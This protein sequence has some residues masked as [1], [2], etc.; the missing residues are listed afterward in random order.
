MSAG[1][2][3]YASPTGSQTPWGD[4]APPAVPVARPGWMTAICI[5]ALI[6]GGLGIVMSLFGMGS[7]LMQEQM[8]RWAKGFGGIGQPK[9]VQDLNDQM[10]T[11]MQEVQNRWWY[12]L[13]A[14]YT[15]N[16]LLS[17]CMIYAA[18]RALA[19]RES[20]RRLLVVTFFAA[21]LFDLLS[22]IPTFIIQWESIEITK[23]FMPRIMEAS[24]PQ[25]QQMPPA[26]K[27]AMTTAMG[28]G[29]IVVVA[30]MG[31]FVLAKII[32]YVVSGLY[33]NKAPIRSLCQARSQPLG[34]PPPGQI[35]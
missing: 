7:L 33:L 35:R 21:T 26:A 11:A 18:A 15:L 13:I 24:A 6:V 10:Q 22:L 31:L 29:M 4:A 19:L 32:F 28:A 2:N 23:E 3:P 27:Q 8:Q 34:V 17:A 30:F 1:S 25:N 20:G 5:L 16:L 9:A 14:Q 12:V